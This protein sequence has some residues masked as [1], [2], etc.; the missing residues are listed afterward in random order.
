MPTGEISPTTI[1][2]GAAKPPR[3]DTIKLA[4][5]ISQSAATVSGPRQNEKVSGII[6]KI[7]RDS[8]PEIQQFALNYQQFLGLFKD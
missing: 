2:F 3:L 4:T 7:L 6:E 8:D 1:L 5:V